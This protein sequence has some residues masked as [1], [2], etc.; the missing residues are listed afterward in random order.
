GVPWY[1]ELGVGAV[2]E[3]NYVH[4]TDEVLRRVGISRDELGA[5]IATKQHEVAQRVRRFRGERS[6]PGLR[7]RTVILVDDGIATGGTVRAAIRSI[8]AQAAKRVVL[9]VPVAAAD[10][11]EALSAEVDRVVCLLSPTD[12]YAIGLW[13]QD[14][15][16]I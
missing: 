12:L 4:L 13:Y 9:A 5:L 15:R 14:F 10:T 7:D 8:R 6:A 11:I 1:R 2:A 3:G 16:Q